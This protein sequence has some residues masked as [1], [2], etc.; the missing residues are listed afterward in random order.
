M[1][2]AQHSNEREQD[3]AKAL[4]EIYDE[5]MEYH[6]GVVAMADV[7]KKY[8]DRLSRFVGYASSVLPGDVSLECK[9]FLAAPRFM[10]RE[11]YAYL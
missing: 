8:L 11:G 1:I 5:E 9:H 7:V 3:L 4:Q 6:N 2:L 10:P